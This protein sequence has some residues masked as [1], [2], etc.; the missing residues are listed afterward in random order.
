MHRKGLESLFT[1]PQ[2]GRLYLLVVHRDNL[3]C[4]P[5]G[6]VAS[7]PIKDGTANCTPKIIPIVSPQPWD[8][9]ACLGKWSYANMVM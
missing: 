2:L 8:I 4:W 7:R 6:A 9:T 3:D 5:Y 1:L